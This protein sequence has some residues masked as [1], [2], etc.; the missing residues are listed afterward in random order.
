[1]AVFIYLGTSCLLFG[2][3]LEDSGQLLDAL[4]SNLVMSYD[5]ND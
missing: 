2:Y 1:M 4:L 3:L 5:C